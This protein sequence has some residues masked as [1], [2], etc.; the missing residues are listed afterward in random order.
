MTP[1]AFSFAHRLFFGAWLVLAVFW[2][3][4]PAGAN[5]ALNS[6]QVAK[7]GKRIWQNECGGTIAGLTSWNT[8]EEFASLGIGH[9]I[10]Y[11][12][13]YEGPFE[14]SF[15]PLVKFLQQRGVAVPAWLLKT[16]DCPWSNREAFLADAQSA[17]QKDLRAMLAASVREQ[18]EFIMAR[19]SQAVPKMVKAGGAVVRQNHDLLA[20]TPEG[21]FAMIDYVNFKGEG[22]NPKER[23]NGEGWGLA[24]VL[25]DMTAQT[26]PGLCPAA[27][28]ESAKRVLARRVKNA[29]AGR[30]ESRWLTGWHNRCDGYKQAL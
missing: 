12:K 21:M 18:T 15:P 11:P 5:T 6:A 13:D 9:F 29:P 16:P 1:L 22:L 28:A 27:F 2:L 17:K 20:Q 7:I 19:L 25:A 30:K 10:W 8:G 23:Y 26:S 14:E 3:P 24:Q 4:C